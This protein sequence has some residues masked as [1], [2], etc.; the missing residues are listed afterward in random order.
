MNGIFWVL[1]AYSTLLVTAWLVLAESRRLLELETRG[2]L[3][4]IRDELFELGRTGTIPFKSDGYRF[5]ESMLNS[6]IRFT[7]DLSF[8]RL[9][10]GVVVAG[11]K[12]KKMLAQYKALNTQAQNS[13]D[14]PGQEAL[15]ALQGKID[16]C[17]ASHII[18]GSFCLL[19]LA[20][21]ATTVLVAVALAR[22]PFRILFRIANRHQS[23]ATKENHPESPAAVEEVQPTTATLRVA[24][25][26]LR[27]AKVLR[28]ADVE[29][30]STSDGLFNRA[31][32]AA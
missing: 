28:L 1:L 4:A 26:T 21:V 17:T 6:M 16:S 30:M 20:V 7:H 32:A 12:R 18:K 5:S 14:K 24:T 9:L 22:L 3:F 2:R 25:I 10:V 31:L 8:T 23:A 27:K 29:A 13:L 19:L 11:S 15:I